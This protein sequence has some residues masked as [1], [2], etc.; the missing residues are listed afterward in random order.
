MGNITHY[1]VVDG[2]QPLIPLCY[3]KSLIKLK[4]FQMSNFIEIGPLTKKSVKCVLSG[5]YST[6]FRFLTLRVDANSNCFLDNLELPE[7]F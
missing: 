3:F 1:S 7:N 6:K 2:L 5:K 4:G